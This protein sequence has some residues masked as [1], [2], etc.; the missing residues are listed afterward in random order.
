MKLDTI[1]HIAIVDRIAIFML[2]FYVASRVFAIVDE[3]DRRTR[4]YLDQYSVRA[5]DFRALYQ[6]GGPRTSEV[7]A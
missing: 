5:S 4:R 7:T 6:I 3:V 2:H 1:H